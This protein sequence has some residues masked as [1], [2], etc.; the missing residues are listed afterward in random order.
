MDDVFD[1]CE[2]IPRD[3]RPADGEGV[4]APMD[5]ADLVQLVSEL[6]EAQEI[7]N[8]GSFR[9][10]VVEG[11]LTSSRQ[12]D[13]IMGWPEARERTLKAWRELLHA[14]DRGNFERALAKCLREGV[15]MDQEYRIVR[16]SDGRTRWLRAIVKAETDDRGK[17]VSVAGVNLDLTEKRVAEQAAHESEQRFLTM[18][19][20]APVL[21]WTADAQS[22]CTYFNRTWLEFT[23]RPLAR[24]MGEGW[25]EGVHPEDL[26]RCLEAFWGSFAARRP[27]QSEFRLRRHDGRYRWLLNNGV[28]RYFP[29]GGFAGYI[30]SCVDITDR[31]ESLQSLQATAA[32]AAELHRC[33]VAINACPDVD[34]A[35]A[36]LLREALHLT[37]MDCGA[38]YL[39][40]NSEVVL[41]HQRGLEPA[42]LEQVARLPRT[43]GHVA[44][45]FAGPLDLVDVFE[46]SPEQR[47]V[48]EPFGIRH[49]LCLALVAEGERI[50]LL[51]VASRA[52]RPPGIPELELLRVL[53]METESAF[54]RLAG[55]QHLRSVLGTVAEGVVVQTADGAITDCNPA[56][57][58][59]LGLSRDQMMGR[60]SVDPRWRAVREDG[61]PFP[62][63]LHPAMEV[64]RT[65][66]PQRNVVMGL[67]L[68]DGTERWIMINS[69]PLFR[70]G[71]ARPHAAVTSFADITE[72]KR[73]ERRL[74]ACEARLAELSSLSG[75][76]AAAP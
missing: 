1:P 51:T 10:D 71:E 15:A 28:P 67:H 58:R 14:D 72:Q 20:A 73:L 27:F 23:G 21:I 55:Q 43:S 65:G 39:I 42:Y 70:G 56:A 16:R 34:S 48:A 11:A 49:H 13:R 76:A 6:T 8:L 47:P 24:E 3:F 57:E 2:K 37:H 54:A 30:G 7:A 18:A 68:P 36:C 45:A 25:T 19:D 64:L 35:L 69:A 17:V 74:R 53:A 9:F 44:A 40:E 46:R 60:T 31:K 75:P 4:T 63:D 61:S 38:I 33:L 26:T 52:V 5:R 62:G 41:C 59:I 50:G 29:D 66:Q 12:L 32:T 22:R